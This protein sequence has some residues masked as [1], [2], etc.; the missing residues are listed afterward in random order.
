MLKKLKNW[1]I[2]NKKKIEA[3]SAQAVQLLRMLEVTR[4]DEISCGDVHELLDQ[5]VEMKM[6][7]EDVSELMPH[8]KRHL[9]M[10]PECFEDYEALL[11]ALVFE[12]AL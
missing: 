5:F 4:E 3:E 1:F 12:E 7:G 6:R 9:D 11:A 8:V 2:P 10:C